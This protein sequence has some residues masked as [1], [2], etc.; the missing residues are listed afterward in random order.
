MFGMDVLCCD[1]TGT[2]TKNELIIDPKEIWLATDH[3]THSSSTTSSSREANVDE[4]LVTAC[5]A[6]KTENQ[7]PIDRAIT[8][9]APE[10]ARSARENFRVLK[11]V[12]FNPVD[13]RAEAHVEETHLAKTDDKAQQSPTTSSSSGPPAL[14]RR[15]RF[16][17]SK[18]A[19]NVMVAHAGLPGE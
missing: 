8:S 12:P 3:D 17:A 9:A 11:F 13:K 10:A 2:L 1:K 16:R 6:C 5:L 18:G 15:R 7:E 14:R 19:P 4:L